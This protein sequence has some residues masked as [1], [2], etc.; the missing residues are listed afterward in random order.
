MIIDD[1]TLF[2]NYKRWLVTQG[3]QLLDLLLTVQDDTSSDPAIRYGEDFA[4]QF[5]T[6]FNL[7]AVYGSQRQPELP[8][9][10]VSF[11]ALEPA[12]CF[13]RMRV[14]FD[15]YFQTVSP[16]DACDNQYIVANTPEAILEYKTRVENALCLMVHFTPGDMRRANFNG[17]PWEVPINYNVNSEDMGPLSGLLT[18]EVLHF[19]TS[20]DLTDEV[21]SC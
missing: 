8:A 5:N 16:H 18:D 19:Q 14:S 1:Y 3:S 15:C 4:S 9:I 6:H 20:F 17:K 7:L 10:L 12:A 13:N 11:Q 2:R 21:S